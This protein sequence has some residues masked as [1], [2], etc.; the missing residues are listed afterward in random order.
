MIWNPST[1]WHA[2]FRSNGSPQR[3]LLRKVNDILTEQKNL[4]PKL[5]WKKSKWLSTAY[6]FSFE[7]LK[8]LAKILTY[9]AILKSLSIVLVKGKPL[10]SLPRSPDT[11]NTFFK[12]LGKH[13]VFYEYSYLLTCKLPSYCSWLTNVPSQ[14]T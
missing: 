5:L 2:L 3:T 7:S 11:S 13:K 9:T 6:K 10:Y 8:Q 12:C 4:R 1:I 14:V